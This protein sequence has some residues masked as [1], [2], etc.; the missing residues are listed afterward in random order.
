MADTTVPMFSLAQLRDDAHR[1]A[2]RACLTGMGV[3]YLTGYGMDERDHRLATRTALDFF[4]HGTPAEKEAVTTDNPTMRRGYSALGAES[5][6][7]VTNTGSYTD[8]SMSYSMGVSGNVFPSPRFAEVWTGYFD[9]L[10]A[11][12]RETARLV[13]GATGTYDAGDMDTLLDCDPVLRLRY[14]PEVPE[15]RAAERVPRRMGPHYD[16]SIIT[17]IHQTPCANGFVS[18]QAE[19]DGEMVDL[20]AV[21]DAVVVMCGAIAPLATQGALPAPRHHVRAPGSGMR[22]GSDRTSSVFFLRPST[23]FTFSVPKARAYGLDVSLDTAT[24]TFGEWIGDNYVT[25]HAVPD[26]PRPLPGQRR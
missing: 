21:P 14:F 24:A 5:T 1:E 23:D 18:L 26:A 13:L 4:E 11:A 3:F 9:R 8:Y 6:A 20:P 25:M 7:Q 16:L 10:Y 12:A 19:I 22:A 15:E 17:L 2:F